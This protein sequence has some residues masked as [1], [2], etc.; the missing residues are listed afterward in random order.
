MPKYLRKD[1]PVLLK[2]VE[3]G[4]T[5]PV[6]LICGERTLCRQAADDLVLRLLPEDGARRQKLIFIDGDQEKPEN[7]LTH[8]KTYSLFPGRRVFLV[9]DT[10]LF[11]SKGVTKN[12]WE[13]ARKANDENNDRL[14]CRYLKKMLGLA[15]LGPADW[16]ADQ[17]A[18]AAA[19]TW[20]SLFGFPKPQ[21]SLAW[22]GPLL[23]EADLDDTSHDSGDP[24]IADLYVEALETGI[25][26]DNILILLAEAVDRRKKLFKVLGKL[27]AVLD[28]TV[29]SGASKKAIEA[30]ETILR[31]LV[32][33]TLRKHGKKMEP[34]AVPML[35]ERVGFHPD[36]VVLETEKLALYCGDQE[37]ITCADLN[38][39]VGRTREEAIFE[40]TEAFSSHKLDSALAILSHMLAQNAHPLMILAGLNNHL[41]RFII[42][43]SLQ[44]DDDLAYSQGMRYPLFQKNY[45]PRLKEKEADTLS[46]LPQHPYALYMLF[47]KVESQ[48]FNYLLKCRRE[49][50]RA[51]LLLKSSPLDGRI[52]LENLLYALL[53]S[54]IRPISKRS[55]IM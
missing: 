19:S 2:E 24:Q 10:K 37:T 20:K 26:V 35:L 38:T 31:D 40:F 48:P 6:Y 5:Y 14:S 25:P 4:K 44:A 16:H 3:S 23:E 11:L 41:R 36:A 53:L 47:Q 50:L 8:L 7:T 39:I 29:E 30:R 43:A 18:D 9:K 27:G 34:R 15:G 13:N 45:L 52:I 22:V 42:V 49:I 32:K 46:A 21:G 17:L 28:L 1:M 12:F 55:R 54:K 51:E 33:A